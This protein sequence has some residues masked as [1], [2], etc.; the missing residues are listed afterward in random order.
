MV[1]DPGRRVRRV[2]LAAF[3]VFAIGTSLVLAIVGTRRADAAADDVR[4]R[5]ADAVFVAADLTGS[6]PDGPSTPVATALGVDATDV[7]LLRD[8]GFPWCVTVEV[9]RLTASR[10]LTFLIDDE[11]G[12]L[13]EV[14]DCPS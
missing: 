5:A 3:A 12:A 4:A 7:S 10:T 1:P 8:V 6:Y 14:D 2:V 11:S 9:D 13:S